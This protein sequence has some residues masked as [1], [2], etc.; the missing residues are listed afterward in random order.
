MV[1]WESINKFGKNRLLA[2]S[3][4]WLVVV[5]LVAKAMSKMESPLD[6]SRY[7][8]GFVIDFSL[9]FSWQIFY[10]SS[11]IISIASAIYFFRCPEIIRSFSTFSEFQKEG[12]DSSYLLSYAEKLEN[13]E[14]SGFAAQRAKGE[15]HPE[16]ERHFN[17]VAFW[18][19]YKH[20]NFR[21]RAI[22]TVCFSLY[23]IGV[24]LIVLVLLDNF[25]YVAEQSSWIS[26]LT[27]GSTGRS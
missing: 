11:V 5:P 22:R 15:I 20:E 8:D 2:T 19:L 24:A 23:I 9:P 3:Y 26:N 25:R 7:V 21:F 12:R 4:V 10:F 17:G 13:F 6:F 1:S 27:S 16:E 14:F 18:Q